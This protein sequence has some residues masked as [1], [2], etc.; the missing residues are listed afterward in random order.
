MLIGTICKIRSYTITISRRQYINKKNGWFELWI[1]GNSVLSKI[2]IQIASQ[3]YH[4]MSVRSKLKD[5]DYVQNL[6]IQVIIIY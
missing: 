3:T 1:N 4:I 6:M 5:N 2:H